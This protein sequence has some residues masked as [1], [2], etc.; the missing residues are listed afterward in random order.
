MLLFACPLKGR[1]TCLSVEKKPQ[2]PYHQNTAKQGQRIR[3][4]FDTK[5]NP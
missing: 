4:F 3:R 2:S 1:L 5:P